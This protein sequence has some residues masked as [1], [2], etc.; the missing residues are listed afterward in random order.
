[1]P[2][3]GT[4]PYSPWPAGVIPRIFS[5]LRRE[6]CAARVISEGRC[7][8]PVCTLSLPLPLTNVVRVIICVMHTHTAALSPCRECLRPMTLTLTVAAIGA[9]AS[10]HS[11]SSISVTLLVVFGEERAL[12]YDEVGQM[13]CCSRCDTSGAEA[14]G[15]CI[16]PAHVNFCAIPGVVQGARSKISPL[17]RG[18]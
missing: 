8:G 9:A 18:P 14:T 6:G 15:R 4:T 11:Y 10:P 17:A 5:R 7:C 2:Y 1:M 3:I 16:H 13:L 12:Q